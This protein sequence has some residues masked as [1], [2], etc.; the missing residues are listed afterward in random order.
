MA[1]RRVTHSRKDR[2]GDI[3]ALGNPGEWWS[4][5]MK[6]NAI[7]DIEGGDHTYYVQAPG[8]S[9]AEVRVVKGQTGK[10]LRSDPDRSSKNNLDNLPDC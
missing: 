1:D 9:R 8:T 10:Y 3:T 2:D 6:A 7:A 5:R 4:P